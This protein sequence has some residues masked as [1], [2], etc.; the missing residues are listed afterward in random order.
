M[1]TAFV[2]TITELAAQDKDVWLVTGDLGYSV[3]EPFMERFPDQ[4]LNV[5][6]AE[7]DLIGV[8][9]GLALAGKRPFAYSISTF[10]SMRAFEQVRNDICYQN[11]PVTV[12]GGGSTFSYSTYGC[13]HFPLEDLSLMRTLPN[14]RVTC[15]GDPAEVRAL[16]RASYENPGPL[17]MRIAKKGE[18]TLHGESDT[19]RLGEASL[20]RD[21]NDVA[22]ISTGRSLAAAS[23]AAD[24]LGKEGIQ[25]RVLSM[26]TIKPLDEGA[27]IAAAN[28][29][30]GLVIIEEHSR[31]GG[32]GSA[33]SEVL[34]RT[35]KT[36]RVMHLAVPDEF[37]S[38]VGSQEYFLRRYGLDAQGVVDASK[39]ILAHA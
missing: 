11:L 9:A 21:G 19:V 32:L 2:D 10:A 38:G 24:A 16:V 34:T 4:Y 23:L 8:C 7:Q 20:M 22:I 28:E 35:G 30:K 12:V 29:T 15:P 36:A 5:G 31:I 18:P 3:F 37:P 14:M 13:T 39:E 17:Y 27:V 25:A 33:V 6:V 26:H 1:R